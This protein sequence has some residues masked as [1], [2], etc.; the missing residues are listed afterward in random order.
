MVVII[1]DI[2]DISKIETGRLTVEIAEFDLSSAIEEVCTPAAARCAG[3]GPRAALEL[4]PSLPRARSRRRRARAPGPREPGRERDQVHPAR[5]GHGPRRPGGDAGGDGIRFEVADTG[6][7]IDPAILDRMFEP[8]VQAD[9]SMTRRYGGNGLGLAIAK[10]LVELM[11]GTIGAQSD[12]GAGSTF[13]FE[14]E[15]PA[16]AAPA[17]PAPSAHRSPPRRRLAAGPRR[18]GQ[19]REPA[20]RDARARARRVPR[21][22]RQRRPRGAPGAHDRA[23]DAVLMDCQMPGLDGYEATRELRRREAAATAARR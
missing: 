18:R 13:R 20:R 14:L 12:P 22:R 5:L 3:G 19:P 10:E 6:I 4:A 15:L 8:F 17:R 16:V 2:L 7:G 21:P 9:V 23:Y 1:N 11:G